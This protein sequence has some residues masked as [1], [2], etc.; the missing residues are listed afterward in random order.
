M[1]FFTLEVSQDHT[2]TSIEDVSQDHETVLTLLTM[3]V[4]SLSSFMLL[5]CRDL[6]EAF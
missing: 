6:F 4:Q 1:F 3:I 2:K 5:I